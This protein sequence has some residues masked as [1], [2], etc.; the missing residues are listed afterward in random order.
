MSKDH[1]FNP[2]S[3][4][5][6][7]AKLIAQNEYDAEER[8]QFRVQMLVRLENIEKNTSSLDIRVSRLEANQK[9]YSD[10]C[11][12]CR[13]TMAPIVEAYDTGKKS[14]WTFG[15]IM[16]GIAFIAGLCLTLYGFFK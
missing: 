10:A 6:Q 2:N 3:I 4:D 5:A 7:L 13:K 1:E 9:I 12:E 8:H 15:K 16:S 14:F 11:I